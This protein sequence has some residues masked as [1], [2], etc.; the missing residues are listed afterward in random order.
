[1]CRNEGLSSKRCSV[2]WKPTWV[3]EGR[4]DWA[5]IGLADGSNGSVADTATRTKTW[6]RMPQVG[7]KAHQPITSTAHMYIIV[8]NGCRQIELRRCVLQKCACQNESV[9]D[10]LELPGLKM[11]MVPMNHTNWLRIV[12]WGGLGGVKKGLRKLAMMA[13]SELTQNGPVDHVLCKLSDVILPTQMEHKCNAFQIEGRM[14]LE[15]KI[16]KSWWGDHWVSN[17]SNSGKTLLV[18]ILWVHKENNQM[19][20]HVGRSMTGRKK[21]G[22][23]KWTAVGGIFLCW[24]LK[25]QA[26]S[27]SNDDLHWLQQRRAWQ[28]SRYGNGGDGC[29]T[30]RKEKGE[31]LIVTARQTLVQQQ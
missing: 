26:K 30:L 2:W 16:E 20:I 22:T 25:H 15:T 3:E 11:V 19:D 17:T 21:R 7:G 12:K 24:T 23:V 27:G 10:R 29:N 13:Q 31:L 18:D 6:K 14:R 9:E 28:L 5:W 1:M 8:S 4:Y